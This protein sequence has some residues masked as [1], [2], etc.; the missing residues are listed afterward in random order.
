MRK[1]VQIDLFEELE[2]RGKNKKKNFY[3]LI[4][5][6]LPEFISIRISYEGLVFSFIVI[7]LLNLLFFSLG[8]ERG[9]RIALLKKEKV[10]ELDKQDKQIQYTIQIKAFNDKKLATQFL[11]ELIEEGYRPFVIYSN[12][13]YQI[14][15]GK[16][17]NKEIAKEEFYKLSKKFRYS[18]IR[19]IPTEIRKEE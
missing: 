2:Y 11:K 12:Q 9:K 16:Y 19:S 5:R 13:V 4:R 8:V 18:F 7:L 3:P 1:E 17:S 15:I 6:L 14:C 10:T